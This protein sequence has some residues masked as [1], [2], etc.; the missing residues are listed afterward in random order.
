MKTFIF[1]NTNCSV[2][3][4]AYKAFKKLIKQEKDFVI[5]FDQEYDIFLH[6]IELYEHFYVASDRHVYQ[7]FILNTQTVLLDFDLDFSISSDKTYEEYIINKIFEKTVSIDTV[8]FFDDYVIKHNTQEILQK[9]NHHNF[10]YVLFVPFNLDIVTEQDRYDNSFSSFRTETVEY[11]TTILTDKVNLIK[12]LPSEK[13]SILEISNLVKSSH[14]VISNLDIVHRLACEYNIPNFVNLARFNHYKSLSDKATIYDPYRN[15]KK[16]IPSSFFSRDYFSI[17][18][19][20]NNYTE[21]PEEILEEI[22]KSFDEH[23]IA[24][25]S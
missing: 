15:E 2:A 25:K 19:Q 7:N 11:L 12:V 14:Y 9:N 10:S 18:G 1:C 6:D 21:H 8:E 13:N 3:F 20:F 5:V 23:S 4:L 22:L 16:Y 17:K 24:Y